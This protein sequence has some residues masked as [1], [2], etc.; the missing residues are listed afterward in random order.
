LRQ[1]GV[2]FVESSIF[3]EIQDIEIGNDV[4]IGNS[5]TILDGAR[6]GDGAIVAAGAVV[7]DNVPP[8]AIAGGVPAKIIRYRFDPDIVAQL[9]D[10]QW[11]NWPIHV[12]KRAQPYI[13]QPDVNEFLR[14]AREH[15]L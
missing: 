6:I 2:T 4:W 13:V 8:Y 7:T 9:L 5:A 10:I 12:L 1:V 3:S 15:G 14:W 11:W